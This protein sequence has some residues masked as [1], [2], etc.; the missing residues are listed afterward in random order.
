MKITE[1][2]MRLNLLVLLMVVTTTA[3]AGD[4]ERFIDDIEIRAGKDLGAFKADLA[5]NF[6]VSEKKIDWMFQAMHRS[7]D[8]YMCLRVGE[9]AH[10]PID[11]VIEEY[12][13]HRGSG[14]GVIA[15]NL[16]I[17]PGSAEFH[18]LKKGKLPGMTS[19]AGH[20][21]TKGKKK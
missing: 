21:K 19:G 3:T 5:V 14:W 12:K 18:A 16:G 15:K 7:S 17:K 2:L 20:N 1:N 6:D 13:L 8:V 4:L 10:Q 9:L 11:R